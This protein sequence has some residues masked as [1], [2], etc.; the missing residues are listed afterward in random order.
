MGEAHSHANSM[1][2]PPFVLHRLFVCLWKFV[3]Y[4]LRTLM[5][6]LWVSSTSSFAPW[7]ETRGW[8]YL[9]FCSCDVHACRNQPNGGRSPFLT[10]GG[11]KHLCA[12][13]TKILFCP[14]QETVSNCSIKLT[15]SQGIEL[16]KLWQRVFCHDKIAQDSFIYRLT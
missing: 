2:Y 13:R 6:K 16:I 1:S 4:T 14:C 12:Q 7:T 9:D 15:F 3:G 8:W 5:K 11:R 10:P